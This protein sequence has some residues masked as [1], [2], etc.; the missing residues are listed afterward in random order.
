[1]FFVASDCHPQTIDVV[2]T[3]AEPLG[4]RVLVGDPWTFDFK[5][6][7]FGA[8]L[9]YPATD[10]RIFEA[11]QCREFISKVHDGGGLAVV[12]ADILALALLTSPAELG[13]D[14]AV[15]STQRFG[16]PIGFGGPHAAY[17]AT[18]DEFKRQV[19]G[20]FVGVS[21]DVDGKNAVRLALQTREQHIRRD[22]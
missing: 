14:V 17:F 9:Q 3:R 12:A 15:G 8:L 2:R 13:A 7:I 4:I 1:G 19:P 11:Q 16:V 20:R 6:P 5:T 10:G 18:K 22:K 21:K